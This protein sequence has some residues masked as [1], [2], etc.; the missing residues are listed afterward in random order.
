LATNNIIDSRQL[1]EESIILKD[2]NT[3]DAT[4]EQ[5]HYQGLEH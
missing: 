5:K 3:D 1:G 2:H 4:N